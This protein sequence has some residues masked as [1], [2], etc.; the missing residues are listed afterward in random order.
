M[1]DGVGVDHDATALGQQ[2]SDRALAA[3]D[4]P[5]QT[6]DRSR[7][8]AASALARAAREIARLKSSTRCSSA[9]KAETLLARAEAPSSPRPEA[10]RSA[11]P[12]GRTRI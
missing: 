3:G 10:R 5:R 1:P 4:A 2:G 9:P 11:D 6:D 7:S 12:T 8:A